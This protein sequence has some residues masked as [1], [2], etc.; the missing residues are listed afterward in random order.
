MNTTLAVA[1]KP[2]VPSV[3]LSA[4]VRD[5]QLTEA[6]LVPDPLRPRKAVRGARTAGGERTW[7][8]K[9]ECDTGGSPLPGCA[10]V[11]VS[12]SG[13]SFE[14][15]LEQ[16]AL[17]PARRRLLSRA[18]SRAAVPSPRPHSLGASKRRRAA[19]ARRHWT[20]V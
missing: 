4:H 13:R 6:V 2:G 14:F 5:E 12:C 17:A 9:Q 20:R 1:V 7:L 11:R 18:C 16:G 19:E 10:T 3:C 15:Q 8:R